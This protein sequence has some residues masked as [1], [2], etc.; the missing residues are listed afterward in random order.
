MMPIVSFLKIWKKVSDWKFIGITYSMDWRKIL[1]PIFFLIGHT[2]FS[3]EI[4]LFSVK[5]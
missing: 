1:N 2:E 5:I 3:M 4:Y